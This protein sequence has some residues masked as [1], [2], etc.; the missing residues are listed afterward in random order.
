MAN[1]KMIIVGTGRTFVSLVIEAY[2]D[3]P[4]LIPSEVVRKSK[5]TMAII[6]EELPMLQVLN[7]SEY[8]QKQSKK[9]YHQQQKD[10]RYL[11]KRK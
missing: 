10:L 6:N 8:I 1:G 5:D 9:N 11:T 7:E 3:Y 4:E 2:R